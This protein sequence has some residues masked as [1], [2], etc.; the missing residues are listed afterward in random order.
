MKFNFNK[1]EKPP[2]IIQKASDDGENVAKSFDDTIEN[3]GF[4]EQN[5][6]AS[7]WKS[8][9][10]FSHSQLA[11]FGAI[12]IVIIITFVLMPEGANF[13]FLS[14]CDRMPPDPSLAHNFWSLAGGFGMGA[15]LTLMGLSAPI[16]ILGALGIWLLMQTSL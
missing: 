9:T 12:L 15:I 3:K 6:S 14:S 16:A 11:M 4:S 2:G 8:M 5:I 7:I 10:R 1:S 13:C